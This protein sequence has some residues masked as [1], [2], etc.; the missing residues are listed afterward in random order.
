MAEAEKKFNLDLMCEAFCKCKTD[1]GELLMDEYIKAYH[2]L[3]NFNSLL[4]TVFNFV[5]CDIRDKVHILEH[6]LKSEQGE[7]YATVQ[8]M[9]L[10]EVEKGTTAKTS[11][12]ASG[13]RTFLRLHRALEFLASFLDKLV[14]AQEGD[15]V[16]WLAVDAYRTTLSKF[17]PWLIRKGAELAMHT[18]PT[19]R[20]LMEKIGMSD[21]EVTKTTLRKTIVAAQ[22]V[23]ASAQDLYTK[24]NLLDLP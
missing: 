6:H 21:V 18:L 17:H 8:K 14:Q 1:D 23:Y 15:K 16:S 3:I 7:H 11:K 19:Q 13:S 5:N 22:E 24:H 20:Q 2:Q 12:V 4:G 10:Y 9:I